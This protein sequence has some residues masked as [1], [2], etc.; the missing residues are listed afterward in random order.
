VG[1]GALFDLAKDPYET[2]DVAGAHAEIVARLRA[3]AQRRDQEIRD[4]RRPAG[5]VKESAR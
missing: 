5:E 2:T 3:E 4:H 1:A